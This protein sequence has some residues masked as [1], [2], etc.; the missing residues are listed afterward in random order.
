MSG[1]L[2][3]CSLLI[4][5]HPLSEYWGV[6]REYMLSAEITSGFM[7]SGERCS[8]TEI[9]RRGAF[10]LVSAKSLGRERAPMQS[11]RL[12]PRGKIGEASLD[13]QNL[14]PRLLTLNHHHLPCPSPKSKPAR[15]VSSRRRRAR[16]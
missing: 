6:E 14:D 3:V 4:G 10:V 12:K 5:G 2:P 11:S 13:P 1:R 15:Y 7:I 16:C 8:V 9:H